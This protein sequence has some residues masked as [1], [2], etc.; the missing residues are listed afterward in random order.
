MQY[1]IEILDAVSARPFA[2]VTFAFLNNSL[3]NNLDRYLSE[4]LQESQ[5]VTST[6]GPSPGLGVKANER[7]DYQNRNKVNMQIV[8]ELNNEGQLGISQSEESFAQAAGRA[9]QQEPSGILNQTNNE[10]DVKD[11][12]ERLY[13][14]R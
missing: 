1:L 9:P 8:D 10:L 11:M 13:P 2:L 14:E 12:V 7:Y 4:I 3:S 5:R 6:G